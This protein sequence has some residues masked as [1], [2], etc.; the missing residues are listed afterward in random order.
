MVSQAGPMVGSARDSTKAKEQQRV[1]HCADSDRGAG[2][3]RHSIGV[4]SAQVARAGVRRDE[5]LY[6]LGRRVGSAVAGVALLPNRPRVD[7]VAAIR[8][9]NSLVIFVRNQDSVRTRHAQ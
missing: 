2:P 7:P 4:W 8:S 3:G 6:Q 1:A 5:A 9:M